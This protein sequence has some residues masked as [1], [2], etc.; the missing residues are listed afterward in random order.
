M[1]D[2]KMET[3]IRVCNLGKNF[4]EK[5]V[6]KNINF[7][8]QLGEMVAI[9]GKSGQGK[10]TLLN[11]LGLIIDKSEGDI[12]H[13]NQKN[14]RYLSRE[15]M[16]LRRNKIG[17]LFQ[18]YGLVDE[19]TV[20]WNLKISLEYKKISSDEKK[21]RIANVL[22]DVGL[23][24]TGKTP[25]YK[26][27]GGEQQRIALARI[28]LQESDLILADE[29]TGSLDGDNRDIVISALSDMKKQGKAILIVTHDPYVAEKCDRIIKL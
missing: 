24:H 14:V 26:L 28:I 4:K 17:Y 1:G 22:H 6:L 19:E 13:F 11:I 2:V 10:S 25:V 21:K 8:L 3:A 18:N 7:E 9:T 5:T 27:S 23:D 29:P 16:L 12:W 20:D 15:G